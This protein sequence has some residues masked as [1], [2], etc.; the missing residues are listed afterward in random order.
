MVDMAKTQPFL[1]SNPDARDDD[2]R[3]QL[4]ELV[5]T[6]R[7]GTGEGDDPPRHIIAG[8]ARTGLPRTAALLPLP[9]AGHACTGRPRTAALMPLPLAGHACARAC[10]ARRPLMPLPL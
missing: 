7:A 1:T 3:D 5:G 2:I 10:L 4:A 9:L 6:R 8:R